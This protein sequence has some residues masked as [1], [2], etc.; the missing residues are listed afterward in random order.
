M[1]IRL[2]RHATLV[3]ELNGI[4]LLVDPMLSAQAAMEPVANAPI[5]ER[6][7]LVG[8]PV[9][10]A[11]LTQI[12]AGTE[13]VLVT[14]CHRDHWDAR[15]SELVP[16]NMPIICQ[17]EDAEHFAASGFSTVLPLT[18]RLSL[19]GVELTRTRGRHGTG[20][21]GRQMGPVCGFVLVAPGEPRLYIAGDTIWCDEVE[22]AVALHRPEVIVVNA[23]GAQFLTGGPITMTPTDVVRVCRSSPGTTVIA[24]H[25]E[26]VNHCMVTRGEL[27]RVIAAERLKAQVTI[28]RDGET[29]HF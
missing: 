21:I 9:D 23:G 25:M 10:Q 15:A 22:E 1:R 14:H 20:A 6:I 29:L 27:A 2:L 26:A 24:V 18:D 19:Q 16:R 8:L 4:R 28:P 13:A 11:G 5:T 17:P 7:P 3:V 12:I